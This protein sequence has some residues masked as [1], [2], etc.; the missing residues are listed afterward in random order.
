MRGRVARKRS[1]NVPERQRPVFLIAQACR[2]DDAIGIERLAVLKH[3][4]KAV[5][6]RIDAPHCPAI[7]VRDGILLEPFAV[8]DECLDRQPL[9][10]IDA[11]RGRVSIKR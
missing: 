9:V 1:R 11:M 8:G 5:A 7:D 10:R 6:R 2:D 3:Q 4:T